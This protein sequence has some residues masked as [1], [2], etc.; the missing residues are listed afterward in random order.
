MKIFSVCTGGHFFNEHSTNTLQIIDSSLSLNFKMVW[1]GTEEMY[2]SK[3][4]DWYI[5]NISQHS[6][7]QKWNLVK[8]VNFSLAEPWKDLRYGES[9]MYFLEGE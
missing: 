8:L 4:A 2:P 5:N 3:L 7:A 6:H 1:W 9:G